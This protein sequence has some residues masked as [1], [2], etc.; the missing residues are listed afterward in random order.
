MENL[1]SR[2][3]PVCKSSLLSHVYK[4]EY[5]D[6]MLCQKCFVAFTQFANINTFYKA[7]KVWNSQE[8]IKSQIY[9]LPESRNEAKKRL[10][11]LLKFNPGK[12][13]IEFGPNTGEFLYV[14]GK[15]GFDITCVDHC[16]AVL[17]LN[18][19]GN[20][21][22]IDSEATK[23]TL[24]EKYDV[25]AAFHLLEHLEKPALF[26]KQIKDLLNPRG[27]LFLEVPNYSSRNRKKQKEK[28]NLFFEYHY[29]HFDAISIKNLLESCGFKIIYSR[30]LQPV[31]YLF[32]PIYL[33]IRHC[34]WSNLK[35]MLGNN[36]Q[37]KINNGVSDYQNKS[38]QL[39]PKDEL[40]IDKS[41][42]SKLFRLEIKA[43]KFFSLP[44]Y[45]F[46]WWVSNKKQGDILQ[47]IATCGDLDE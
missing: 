9:M 43:N 17:S 22:F 25:V 19:S 23:A 47:I 21:K 44:L 39:S 3:C 18:K 42:K 5:G 36:N 31:N 45:P 7:N 37:N 10:K 28:W 33:P 4:L 29:M 12:K 2:N 41:I 34:L 40:K 11:L 30:T 16:S 1:I 35:K 24:N 15:A 13:L 8:R 32:A 46:A 26:I 14:A 38:E 27:I 6:V 20:L